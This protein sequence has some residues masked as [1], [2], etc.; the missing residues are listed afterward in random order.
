MEYQLL[1]STLLTIESSNLRST[2]LALDMDSFPAAN[3]NLKIKSDWM[4]PAEALQVVTRIKNKLRKEN[5]ASFVLFHSASRRKAWDEITA[6]E[7]C[8]RWK[9][10]RN[11]I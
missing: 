8:L 1:Q 2:S 4:T 6:C 7:R 5:A 9:Y 3:E 11:S 10:F